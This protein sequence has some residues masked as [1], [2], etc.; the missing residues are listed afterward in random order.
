MNPT[1]S[2]ESMDSATALGLTEQA[3]FFD[4]EVSNCIGIFYDI[5]SIYPVGFHAHG[6]DTFQVRAPDGSTQVF[7]FPVRSTVDRIKVCA[8]NDPMAIFQL[9]H[10]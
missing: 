10:L 2:T 6:T 9:H 4:V 1:L 7:K 8:Y 5:R 3:L